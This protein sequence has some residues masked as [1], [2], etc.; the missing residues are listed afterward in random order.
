MKRIVLAALLMALSLALATSDARTEIPQ[1]SPIPTAWELEFE[2]QAPKAI[3]VTL[4]GEK[5]PKTF[6]Y[7]VYTVNNQTDSD[8]LFVPDIVLFTETGQTL[9][10]GYGVPA[11]V[12]TEIKKVQ[13]DPL[14]RDVGSIA[15]RLLQGEDNAKRGVAIW[16]DYDAAA[17]AFD[18][19]ISGLSGETEE[20]QLPSPVEVME[21]DA[22]GQKKAVE[23]TKMILNKT[24]HLNY[25]VTGEAASRPTAKPVL[26]VKEWVMR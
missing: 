12:F 24:L 13:N 18:I 23:K 1:P 17:G 9:R 20:I 25:Q 5:T 11:Q 2:H 22:A 6:W 19:F 21:I 14:L 4:P 7:L 15:G 16:P 26:K 8:Q 10:A 3:Q